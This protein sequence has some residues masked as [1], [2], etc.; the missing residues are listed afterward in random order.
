MDRALAQEKRDELLDAASN[1]DDSLTEKIL[2]EEEIPQDELKAAIRTGVL[3]GKL[4]QIG[5]AH[6]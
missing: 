3:T 4:N 6:V 2:M 5:R 1:F